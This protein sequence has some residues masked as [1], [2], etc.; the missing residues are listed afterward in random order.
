MDKELDQHTEALR[1]ER[2]NRMR[3][4]LIQS[5]V[6]A[7][8]ETLEGAH[9]EVCFHFDDGTTMQITFECCKESAELKHG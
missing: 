4:A 1:E 8:A 6:N 7:G 9:G 3:D 2:S 5:V